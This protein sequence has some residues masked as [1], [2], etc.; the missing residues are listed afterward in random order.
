MTWLEMADQSAPT[1]PGPPTPVQAFYIGGDTPHVWTDAEIAA[2]KAR[3]GLPIWVNTNPAADAGAH[4]ADIVKWLHAHHYP[5]GVAVALDTESG[6]MPEYVGHVDQVVTA[7][8]YE[9]I[10][11]ESKGPVSHNPKTS[12]G[13][14]VA[15]WT[16]IPHMYQGSVAT[17]YADSAMAGVP[18]DES[19]IDESVK[20]FELH[21][22]VT[23]PIPWAA[24]QADVPILAIG[25]RGPAVAR[26]QG[27]L[28]A[29][30]L[31]STGPEGIDGIFGP[32]TESALRLFQRMHGRITDAGHCDGPT[33]ELLLTA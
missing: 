31:T 20:L 1:V 17:Q 32:D 22:P 11:Y 10:E 15:D 33:W 25:D 2:I 16:G 24:I 7:A 18:W 6:I 5:R 19:V 29:W 9:L 26:M 23:H 14:W 8:G 13:R 4:A 27:L 28:E 3:F 30:R 21:P 12:G